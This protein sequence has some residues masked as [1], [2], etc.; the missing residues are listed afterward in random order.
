MKNIRN[1]KITKDPSAT[2]KMLF[3]CNTIGKDDKVVYFKSNKRH[4]QLIIGKDGTTHIY[5]QI[6]DVFGDGW[7][8]SSM[9][10]E[11]EEAQMLAA[12]LSGASKW[13]R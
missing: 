7:Y 1:I 10:L 5:R 2:D 8:G 9:I 13:T 11:K 6:K 3:D 4:F 12:L